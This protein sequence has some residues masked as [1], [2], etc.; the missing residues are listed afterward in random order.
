MDS[1]SLHPSELE[2]AHYLRGSLAQGHA[3]ALFA[4]T[5]LCWQCQERLE[6]QLA[7]GGL[8]MAP[9]SFRGTDESAS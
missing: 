1:S 5:L 4:H 6:A 7:D 8:T 3:A 2:F 9:R